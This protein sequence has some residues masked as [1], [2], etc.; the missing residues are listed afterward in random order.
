MDNKRQGSAIMKD[1]AS[2]IVFTV[3]LV[4]LL[5]PNLLLL[6]F[7]AVNHQNIYKDIYY[8]FLNPKVKVTI[9]AE[10]YVDG[11]PVAIDKNSVS[12]TMDD[13]LNET[14]FSA[15]TTDTNQLT[16]KYRAS[17]GV[18]QYAFLAGDFKVILKL[19]HFNE[20]EVNE[21][22]YTISIDSEKQQIVYEY[23]Y[24]YPDEETYETI[25]KTGEQTEPLQKENTISQYH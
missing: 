1:K 8:H 22:K 10:V 17:Y 16:I 21:Y 5:I 25:T 23:E 4:F 7:S 9:H 3:F 2:R 11:E 19:P 24:R 12:V 20:W 13:T 6:G 14:G 15:I 18:F